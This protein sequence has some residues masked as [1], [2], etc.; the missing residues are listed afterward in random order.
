MLCTGFLNFCHPRAAS[1]P[2]SRE[3]DD[4][5]ETQFKLRHYQKEGVAQPCRERLSGANHLC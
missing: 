3:D 1:A 2:R 5:Y 4:L